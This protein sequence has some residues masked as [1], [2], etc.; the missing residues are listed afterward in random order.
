MALRVLIVDDERLARAK[1]RD[2]L[3]DERDV[4]I[5]GE[6]GSGAEATAAVR[7]LHPDVVF[8]DVQ[9]PDG[10]GFQTVEELGACGAAIVFVSAYDEYA[11]QAFDVAAVDYL[12]K[13]Y[14]R[15]RLCRALERAR[16]AVG[17]SRRLAVRDGGRLLLLPAG[18]ID[19]IES[20]GNY[21]VLHAGVREHIVR[22]ALAKL[23]ARLDPRRFV[24]IHR[25]AI[26]NL[27]AVVEVRAL[28]H[29]AQE[30][31]LRCG[32]RLPVGRRFRDRLSA[33]GGPA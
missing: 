17:P 7:S 6:C 12:L 14:D 24:R 30:V 29:G 27:D 18:E 10:D 22:E 16:A 32:A 4:V 20:A 3:V 21:V 26:V 15:D 5:V 2:Y 9:M 25:R 28:A 31:V 33:A 11:V 23:E 19:W 13:P 8:L 1:I